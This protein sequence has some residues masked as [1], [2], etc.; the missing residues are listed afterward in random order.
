MIAALKEC[1]YSGT[2][3]FISSE[4]NGFELFRSD[5]VDS[6]IKSIVKKTECAIKAFKPLMTD[7]KLKKVYQECKV[8][9][10]NILRDDMMK[11]TTMEDTMN[12]V[13]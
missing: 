6:F 9:A 8:M 7:P 5:K 4:N 12:K 13:W 10:K 1:L 11:C 2:N 3:S